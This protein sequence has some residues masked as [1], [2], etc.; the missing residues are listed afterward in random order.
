MGVPVLICDDSGMARKQIARALPNQWD[1][2][3]SFASNGEEGLAAL[4][5]LRPAVMFLDLTMPV[6]DGYEVLQALAQ[7]PHETLVIVVSGDVQPAARQRVLELGAFEFIRK[8]IDRERLAAVLVQA[9][10]TTSGL[11]RMAAAIGPL[12]PLDAYREVVNVAMGQAA[13]LLA[14]LL[15]VF[16]ILPVPKVNLLE[17]AELGAVLHAVEA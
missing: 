7:Q 16:V 14:R 11:P 8:P 13:A 1:V 5:R 4:H 2:E 12:E 15:G 10:F 6:L 3:L 17:S 9:G